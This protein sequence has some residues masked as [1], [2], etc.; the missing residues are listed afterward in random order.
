MHLISDIRSL[1]LS[2]LDLDSRP[3]ILD[4]RSSKILGPRSMVTVRGPAPRGQQCL[5]PE[6]GKGRD[7]TVVTIM[8]SHLM[9]YQC[10][11]QTCVYTCMQQKHTQDTY[12]HVFSLLASQFHYALYFQIKKGRERGRELLCISFNTRPHRDRYNVG[13]LGRATNRVRSSVC[14]GD[15]ISSSLQL[16]ILSILLISSFQPF[17]TFSLSRE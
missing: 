5:T 14:V 11:Y 6:R 12:T 17:V 2:I 13:T 8:V 16:L 9:K 7:R 3:K 10:T 1:V 4:S 15:A